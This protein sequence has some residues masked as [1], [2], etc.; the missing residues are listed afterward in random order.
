MK[1]F[2][3]FLIPILFLV[4]GCQEQNNKPKL[5][6][7]NDVTKVNPNSLY[8]LSK[9]KALERQN[10]L[11][12]AKIQ[13]QAK[14]ETEKIKAQKDI[15]VAKVTTQAQK[16]ITTKTA[17]TNLEM[18]KIEAQ[19]K[20][21]QSQ[22]SLYIAILFVLVILLA[23]FLWYKHKKKTLEIK[24]KLE[25]QRLEHQKALKEREFQEQRIHK[26]LELA[27]DGKLPKEVQ[28][29]VIASI[30]KTTNPTIE[31]KD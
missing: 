24:E 31:H 26:V 17:T 4:L 21:K 13:A 28:K 18:S 8:H 3:I 15:E 29:D 30:T 10:K 6:H 7:K 1:L 27:A 2:Y 22:V 23:L 14:V 16:E 11:E 25:A 5:L 12:I 9:D 19:T 20:E